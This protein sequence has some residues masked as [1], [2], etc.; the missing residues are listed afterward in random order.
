MKSKYFS[1]ILI[2]GIFVTLADQLLKWYLPLINRFQIVKNQ[3]ILFPN[4]N[5]WYWWLWL[6]AGVVIIISLFINQKSNLRLGEILIL[7]GVLSNLIDR[8]FR[9]G[10]IDYLN[11]YGLFFNLADIFIILGLVIYFYKILIYEK[12]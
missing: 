9:G 4:P 8:L 11:I 3:G 1:V 2:V 12:K 10:V 5:G 6:L 7:A